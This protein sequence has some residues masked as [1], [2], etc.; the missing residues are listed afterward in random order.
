M[1]CWECNVGTIKDG[2]LICKEDG[3]HVV[4]LDGNL[5]FCVKEDTFESDN[6]EIDTTS[7]VEYCSNAE[8]GLNFCN[9]WRFK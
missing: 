6:S 5:L 2:K 3:Y 9:Y 4:D 8:P 1:N 7:D